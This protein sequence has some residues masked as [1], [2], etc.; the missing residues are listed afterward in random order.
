MGG[1]T[2][3]SAAD[4]AV[5]TPTNAATSGKSFFI[6]TPQTRIFRELISVPIIRL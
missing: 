3:K 5:A 1:A 4:A 2:G 6:L